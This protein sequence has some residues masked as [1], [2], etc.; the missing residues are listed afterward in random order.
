MISVCIATYN[1]E[2]H[3]KEQI[4]SI[5]CQLGEN[6]EII[7]SDDGSTDSSIEIIKGFNDKRIILLQHKSD[8]SFK[9]YPFRKVSKNFENAINHATGDLIFLADQ[10]DIWMADKVPTVK[11]K[12]GNSLLLLHDCVVIDEQGIELNSSYFDLNR[13]KQGIINNLINCSFLGCCIVIRKEL[14]KKALPLPKN[15]VP[16]DLWFGLIS[17]WMKKT[18]VIDNKLLL[19]RRHKNNFSSS[20]K[21]SEASIAYKIRYRILIIFSLAK[22]MMSRN[23]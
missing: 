1:G 16:H 13:S 18:I 23:F 21:K 8:V 20:G 4:D 14:L 6:D 3:I 7:I 11:K 17:T 22:R 2:K 10:D 9:K 19:Y 15:S 12:M 5:L